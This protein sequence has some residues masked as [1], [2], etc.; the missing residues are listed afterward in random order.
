MT[1]SF[2]AVDIETT[3]LNPAT[4]RIIEIGAVR[5]REGQ[6]EETFDTLINPETALSSFITELTGITDEMLE[7]AP[8][9]QTA[10]EDF[11]EFAGE[12]VLL[13]HHISF[14]YSFLKQNIIRLNG[15]FERTGMDTLKIARAALPELEKRSLTHLCRY[16]GIHNAH[17]HRACDDALATT[18]LFFRLKEDFYG[19]GKEMDRLFLP[20]PLI[21]QVKKDSPITPAQLRYLRALTEYHKLELEAKPESLSKSEASRQI[22]KIILTCGKIPGKA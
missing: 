2:V 3:G 5:V 6:I 7:K 1:E 15:K 19:K 4:D 17:A 13:G 9:I 14:D 12:D 8:K 11:L 21:Y 22:D 16:Y 20:T 18:E 10:L